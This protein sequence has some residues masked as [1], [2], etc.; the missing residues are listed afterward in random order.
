MIRNLGAHTQGTHPLLDLFP[1]RC[2]PR[3]VSDS[4]PV[5]LF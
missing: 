2:F 5:C 3:Y 1:C 4:L